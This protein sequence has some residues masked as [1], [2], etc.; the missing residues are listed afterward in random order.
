MN[1]T[2]LDISKR[3]IVENNFFN[4]FFGPISSAAQG[5]IVSPAQQSFVWCSPDYFHRL[6]FN[7]LF[8]EKIFL[9]CKH[10]RSFSFASLK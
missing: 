9:R 1:Y 5:R 7:T 2:V 3:I 8:T 6:F 4:S 10:Y